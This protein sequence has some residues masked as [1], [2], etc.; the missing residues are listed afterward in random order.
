MKL[1]KQGLAHGKSSV[2]VSYNDDDMYYLYP[3]VG[4]NCPGYHSVMA[5][6]L[7]IPNVKIP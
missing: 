4:D 1:F 3:E 5:A 7:A 6:F 2:N